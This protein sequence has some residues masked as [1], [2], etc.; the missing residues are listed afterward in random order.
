MLSRLTAGRERESLANV[1]TYLL[2]FKCRHWKFSCESL[3]PSLIRFVCLGE[4]REGNKF[5]HQYLSVRPINEFI[6]YTNYSALPLSG[7]LFTVPISHLPIKN[8]PLMAAKSRWNRNFRGGFSLFSAATKVFFYFVR[9]KKR[10]EAKWRDSLLSRSPSLS[11]SGP[12]TT[13]NNENVSNFLSFRNETGKGQKRLNYALQEDKKAIGTDILCWM[14]SP[15]PPIIN[16]A[17]T[18]I[19]FLPT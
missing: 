16:E 14:F 2:F 5:R 7:L 15:P 12:L 18:S 17:A 1:T 11:W 9:T 8:T 4:I 10:K 13:S 19:C 6:R 3:L